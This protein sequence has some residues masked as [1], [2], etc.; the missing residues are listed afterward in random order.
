VFCLIPFCLSQSS[1][2]KAWAQSM[3]T[4]H[5]ATTKKP[6]LCCYVWLF[7]PGWRSC[8]TSMTVH[9][10][11]NYGARLGEKSRYMRKME[12]LLRTLFG[13]ILRLSVLHATNK[14]RRANMG[15]FYS[16][17]FAQIFTWDAICFMTGWLASYY[18]LRPYVWLIRCCSKECYT[19]PLLP[20]LREFPKSRENSDQIGKRNLGLGNS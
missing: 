7:L 10:N 12:N 16:F 1:Q 20:Y 17:Q 19:S 11:N 15:Y 5:K 2:H 6:G 9:K 3:S 13:K 18:T 4:K 8:S 14:E